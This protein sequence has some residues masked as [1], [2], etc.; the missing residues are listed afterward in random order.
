MEY[1]SEKPFMI[2]KEILNL[3]PRTGFFFN[4]SFIELLKFGK[5]RLFAEVNTYFR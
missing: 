1:L 2:R 3:V 4:G 5:G